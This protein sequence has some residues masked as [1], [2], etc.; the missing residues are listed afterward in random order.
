MAAAAT[1]IL[2]PG[3]QNVKN[4]VIFGLKIHFLLIT[5]YLFMFFSGGLILSRCF[6]IF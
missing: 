3:L 6:S 2:N 4:N 5:S 1:L